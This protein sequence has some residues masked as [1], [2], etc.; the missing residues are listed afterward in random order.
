MGEMLVLVAIVFFIGAIAV[1]FFASKAF[2]QKKS[3]VRDFSG[4]DEKSVED[5]LSMLP[6]H[7]HFKVIAIQIFNIIAAFLFVE[8]AIQCGI[9]PFIAY[10]MALIFY[11][12][13]R[14]FQAFR[15]D[16]IKQK[17]YEKL[18]AVSDMILYHNRIG[19]PIHLV[20]DFLEKNVQPP[21]KD[22]FVMSNQKIRCGMIPY[23]ALLQ[24]AKQ[25]KILELDLL[26][27]ILALQNRHG[28]GT[29]SAFLFL[30]K[31]WRNQLILKKKVQSILAENRMTLLVLA[32]MPFVVSFF[33]YLR[34]PAEFQQLFTTT[35]G[36]M[37]FG[38]GVVLYCVGV[39]TFYFLSRIE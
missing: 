18:P 6:S 1:I 39:I 35:A 14:V 37:V 4:V 28:F 9:Q 5:I 34:N 31:H 21:L 19:T 25:Y 26:A 10:G 32:A 20:L 17:L 15:K 23:K 7:D 33:N 22:F 38:F 30:S 16:K 29:Q 3:A 27:L 12:A 11:V 24:T 8:I 13:I 36:R 2:M